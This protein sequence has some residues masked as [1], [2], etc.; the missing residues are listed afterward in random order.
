M[1]RL[2]PVSLKST[3]LDRRG[4]R[5]P[6]ISESLGRQRSG[7]AAKIADNSADEFFSLL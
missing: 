5:T 1:K 7:G 3:F 4:S 2:T 6:A